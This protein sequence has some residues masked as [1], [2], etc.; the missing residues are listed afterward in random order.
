MTKKKSKIEKNKPKGGRKRGENCQKEPDS[1]LDVQTGYKVS[2]TL[3]H[4]Y[5]AEKE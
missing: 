3:S 1:C 4:Y 5:T 2:F